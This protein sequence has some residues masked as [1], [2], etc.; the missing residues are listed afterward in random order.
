MYSDVAAL[1]SNTFKCELKIMNNSKNGS[2]TPAFP[3][4][5][6]VVFRHIGRHRHDANYTKNCMH[7]AVCC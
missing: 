5:E 2:A 3:S 4:R 7:L 6:N 1:N